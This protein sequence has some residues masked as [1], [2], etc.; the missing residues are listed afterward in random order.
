[1]RKKSRHAVS[2]SLGQTADMKPE[3]GGGERF[4]I[5]VKR[6]YPLNTEPPSDRNSFAHRN[7]VGQAREPAGK[8]LCKRQ[9]GKYIFFSDPIS[10][11]LNALPLQTT[12]FYSRLVRNRSHLSNQNITAH[13]IENKGFLKCVKPLITKSA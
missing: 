13:L 5:K 1:M 4:A 3:G 11:R 12:L 7:R 6:E 8:F 10:F 9:S 2:E